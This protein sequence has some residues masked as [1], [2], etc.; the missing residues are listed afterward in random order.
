VNDCF[1]L[2][3]LYIFK[4]F[5]AIFPSSTIG[6]HFLITR[7]HG[8]IQSLIASWFPSHPPPLPHDLNHTIECFQCFGAYKV[9]IYA[10]FFQKMS[11]MFY[12]DPA[13]ASYLGS[14]ETGEADK[15]LEQQQIWFVLCWCSAV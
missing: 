6:S 4:I 10:D 2:I 11:A 14:T 13:V 1:C 7:Q 9:S 5:C 3:D 8:T 15:H 12:F